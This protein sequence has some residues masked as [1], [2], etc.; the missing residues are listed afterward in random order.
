MDAAGRH[1]GLSERKEETLEE[2]N[3]GAGR[4]TEENLM[5]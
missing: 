2:E 4:E 5:N 3:G 1:T